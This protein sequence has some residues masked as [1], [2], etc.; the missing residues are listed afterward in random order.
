[1]RS[2]INTRACGKTANLPHFTRVFGNGNKKRQEK[3]LFQE[4]E[5]ENCRPGADKNQP[6]AHEII[7]TGAPL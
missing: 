4:A 1:M 2:Y 5:N 3:R 6:R 7:K